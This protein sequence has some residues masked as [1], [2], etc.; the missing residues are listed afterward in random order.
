MYKSEQRDGAWLAHP[1]RVFLSADPPSAP[2]TRVTV[3]AVLVS[4]SW[5]AVPLIVVPIMSLWRPR[6]YDS[7]TLVRDV[8][9][10]LVPIVLI[11]ATVLLLL[12][13]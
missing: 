5:G 4:A 8:L 11:F 2:D 7:D 13:S 9:L 3:I 12:F 6:P 1:L 10:A